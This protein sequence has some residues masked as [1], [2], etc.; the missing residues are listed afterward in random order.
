MMYWENSGPIGPDHTNV[1]YEDC[2]RAS[3]VYVT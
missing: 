2:K 1:A 3:L